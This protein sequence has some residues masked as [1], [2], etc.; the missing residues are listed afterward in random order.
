MT[1]P[2][3]GT[4][5]FTSANAVSPADVNLDNKVGVV[6][7]P[8]TTVTL[9]VY[10]MTQPAYAIMLDSITGPGHLTGNMAVIMQWSDPLTSQIVTQERWYYPGTTTA[11]ASANG[12][13]AGRGPTKA[14]MLT[15][16]IR[17]YDTTVTATID[18][19][20]WQS[21]RQVTRDDWRTVFLAAPVNAWTAPNADHRAGLMGWIN[22][23]TI[24]AGTSDTR[25]CGLY[26]GEATL[27]VQVSAFASVTV[28]VTVP[29]PS[30]SPTAWP[31][32]ASIPLTANQASVSLTLPRCPV[33][34][35][36]ANAGGAAITASWSLTVQEV[37]S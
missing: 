31:V 26:S 36:V 28:T 5:D 37:A 8:L 32:I 9:G 3:I 6:V 25:I 14:A 35:K 23:V 17:N 29:L 24:N 15:V 18:Y 7:A 2:A 21:S 34:I 16:L 11:P 12:L 1:T 33:S 10:L 22:N 20:L 19:A 4:G 30:F 27:A 13:M